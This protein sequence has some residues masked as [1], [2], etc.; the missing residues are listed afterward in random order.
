[1]AKKKCKRNT[2]P[3]S[4]QKASMFGCGKKKRKK[5]QKRF[6]KEECPNIGPEHGPAHKPKMTL[7]QQMMKGRPGLFQMCSVNIY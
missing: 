2:G 4:Y 3:V 7:A 6:W 1:M 5:E